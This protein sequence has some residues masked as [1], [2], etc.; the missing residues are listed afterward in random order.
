MFRLGLRFFLILSLFF[1]IE[2]ARFQ[3]IPVAGLAGF[4]AMV[5]FVI[6]SL[7]RPFRGPMASPRIPIS[8]STIS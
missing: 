2:D 8:S 5:L 7:D 4:L 6:I 1:R 3:G